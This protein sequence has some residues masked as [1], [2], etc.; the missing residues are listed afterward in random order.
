MNV[1]MEE[2]MNTLINYSIV[3][4]NISTGEQQTTKI[5]DLRDALEERMLDIISHIPKGQIS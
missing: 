3:W 4:N 2:M 1:P 5:N